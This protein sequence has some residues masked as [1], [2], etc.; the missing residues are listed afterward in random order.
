VIFRPCCLF[1]VFFSLLDNIVLLFYCLTRKRFLYSLFLK[2]CCL[3]QLYSETLLV[4]VCVIRK[5]PTVNTGYRVTRG[6]FRLANSLGNAGPQ[7]TPERE[8]RFAYLAILRAQSH[9][10]ALLTECL[11]TYFTIMDAHPYV[12]FDVS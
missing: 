6:C 2:S 4:F 5:L 12:C 8:V 1:K 7:C 11:I 3:I 10:M 9:Q